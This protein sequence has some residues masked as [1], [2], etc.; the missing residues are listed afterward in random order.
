LRTPQ[1]WGGGGATEAYEYFLQSLKDELEEELAVNFDRRIH[2]GGSWLWGMT[3]I[4]N[5]NIYHWSIED[6]QIKKT[7]LNKGKE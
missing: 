2:S 3:A 5:K 6:H 1:S 7:Q 4:G